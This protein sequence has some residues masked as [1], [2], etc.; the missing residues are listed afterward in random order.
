ML[1]GLFEDTGLTWMKNSGVRWGARYRYFTKGWVNNWGWGAYDGSWGLHY[2]R[3]CDGQGFV[4]AVQYYQM[5]GEPGGGEWQM[6]AK[7]Q[8]ASTMRSYFGDFKIWMQRVKEFG[9]PVLIL[10]EGD[11]YA[12]LQAQTGS[13]PNAYAAVAATG[14]PELSS[15]P[16]TV[17]GWGMAFLQ[18]RKT[19][20]ANN[21]ILGMHISAWASG[22]DI[23]HFSVTD[24][25]GPEVDKVYNFL[26]PLGLRS[27]QTGSTYDVLVGDPLDR[28]A[29]YYRLVLGQD[30]WWDASDTA[31]INSKSFNRYAE[32]LGIWNQK[33]SKRWVLW[34]IPLGN[35]NHLN[36]YNNGGPREGYKD[37][38]PEYFFGNGTAHLAK[39]ADSGVIALLFGVGTGGQAHFETDYYTDGQLFMK[40]RAGAILNAGGV[41]LASSGTGGSDAGT[42]LDSGADGSGGATGDAGTSDAGVSS[43]QAQYNFESGTQGWASSGGMIQ[44]VTSSAARSY[45]GSRSLAVSLNGSAPDKRMVAVKVPSTPAGK[46][47]KFRIWFPAGSKLSSIQPYVL[48]G[49]AGGWLWSGAWRATSSL[50]AGAWNTI[51][52]TVPATAQTP[53]D[54]LGV[55]LA[56]SAAWTGTVYV[57]SVG[58]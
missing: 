3:E 11:G 50:T 57:D 56:T 21:A 46:T 29:D 7:V 16:N 9:K 39:F 44:S 48:Q 17:A 6:L 22:K 35:S 2:L 23:S 49:A 25:L 45:A 42:A 24:P 47:V 19:V 33:A 37:N 14:I 38:R 43:D 34:Q 40:S 30:R 13:N 41:L 1:V 27:N 26:A 32:W 20:G 10:L 12:F 55:E 53:L 5:F 36:V 54:Q 52:V 51:S 15:L 8:N 18:L 58:W 31:S 28:D 4:P